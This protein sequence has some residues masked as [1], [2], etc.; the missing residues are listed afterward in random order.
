MASF[1]SKYMKKIIVIQHPQSEQH[2]NRMIGSWYDWDL[3]ELGIKQAHN[4][5]K[6]LSTEITDDDYTIYSSDLL[7]TKHTA[8]IISSYLHTTPIFDERI[9]EFNLGEAI[10]KSKDWAKNNL[11]C[12]VWE[13]TIDW[14][15]TADGQV[16]RNAETRRDVWN[17]VIQFY[18]DVIVPS[19][20]NLIIVSHSGTLSILFAIWLGMDIHSLDQTAIWGKAGG[21]SFLL[22]DGEHRMISKINDMSYIID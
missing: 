2:I 17:R 9:R 10:G 13:G 21:V 6:K 12:P 7:R 8:D 15:C 18:N 3:T 1:K 4:I 14:A 22:D 5:A 16:F 20:K 11:C 19:K